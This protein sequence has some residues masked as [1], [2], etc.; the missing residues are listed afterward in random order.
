MRLFIKKNIDDPRSV[1]E[2]HALLKFME[3]NDDPRGIVLSS[4]YH[5]KN[6]IG[7]NY[8]D[9]AKKEFGNKIPKGLQIGIKGDGIN[10]I[11]VFPIKENKSWFDLGC[12]VNTKLIL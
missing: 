2:E 6:N 9:V 5:V 7:V 12:I 1:F 4:V 10:G 11:V 8:L 3:P